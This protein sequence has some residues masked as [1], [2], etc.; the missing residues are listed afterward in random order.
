MPSNS[1][2]LASPS[3][4]PIYGSIIEG[5][6]NFVVAILHLRYDDISYQGEHQVWIRDNIKRD[7]PSWPDYGIGTFSAGPLNIQAGILPYRIG[8]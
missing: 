4:L 2:A 1:P 6:S 7:I 5:D 3:F 8:G